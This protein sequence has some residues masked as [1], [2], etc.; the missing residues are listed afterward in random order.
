MASAF[1]RESEQLLVLT[2]ANYL[3]G[4]SGDTLNP[5]DGSESGWEALDTTFGTAASDEIVEISLPLEVLGDLS[6]G[7]SL[8]MGLVIEPDGLQMPVGGPVGGHSKLGTNQC[9]F[10]G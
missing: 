9:I 8:K 3:S 1:S 2:P 5:Y 6:A 7:D 10:G 4:R